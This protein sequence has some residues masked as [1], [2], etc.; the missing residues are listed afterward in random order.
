[1]I[2][3]AIVVARAPARY[4]KRHAERI[5]KVTVDAK[6]KLEAPVSR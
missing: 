1:M 2:T 6:A 4:R 3:G 5:P